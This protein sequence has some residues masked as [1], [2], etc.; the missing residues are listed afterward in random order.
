LNFIRLYVILILMFDTLSC[1]N[2]TQSHNNLFITDYE[3]GKML[4]ENPRGIGC[5]KCHG[6]YGKKMFISSYSHK[7]QYKEIYAPSISNSSLN[8]FRIKLKTKINKKSIM[9]TYFLTDEEIKI[10]HNYITNNN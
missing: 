6:K 1:K 8:V 10:I 5:I 7:T 3:Y 2:L 9:P 4:Y